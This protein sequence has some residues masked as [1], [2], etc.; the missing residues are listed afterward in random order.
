MII[1]RIL[2]YLP[3]AVILL[4]AQSYFW[5]PTFTDQVKGSDRRLRQYIQGSIGDA[6]IRQ[7]RAQLGE[8]VV[9]QTNLSVVERQQVFDVTRIGVGVHQPGP[10]GDRD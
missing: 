6:Q 3:L 4:L 7:R 9:D 2:I 5:V 10:P 8:M 1:K